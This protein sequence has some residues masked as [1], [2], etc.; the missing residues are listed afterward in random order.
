MPETANAW[1]ALRHASLAF[2]QKPGGNITRKMA[3][4]VNKFSF[5][6]VRHLVIFKTVGKNRVFIP[7]NKI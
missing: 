6:F 1:F 3:K 5:S 4:T 7:E 2:R